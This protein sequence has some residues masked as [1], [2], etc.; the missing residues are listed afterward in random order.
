MKKK[1]VIAI[2]TV[3]YD[4]ELTLDK[5]T[6]DKLKAIDIDEAHQYISE[7]SSE[8]DENLN[9]KRFKFHTDGGVDHMDTKNVEDDDSISEDEQVTRIDRMAMEIED[10]LKQQKE[11]AM[12]VDK[13]EAKKGRKAK[14]LIEL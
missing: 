11:Y 2:N 9:E 7:E 8:E 5:K 1:S 3:N 10:T 13:K 12:L 6:W 14:A 4:D